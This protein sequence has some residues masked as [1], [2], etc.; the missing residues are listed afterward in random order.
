MTW[1]YV[2]ASL[3][4]SALTS[5]DYCFCL[6]VSYSQLHSISVGVQEVCEKPE[7]LADTF[8]SNPVR[9]EVLR[10]APV[11]GGQLLLQGVWLTGWDSQRVNQGLHVVG[12][13]IL[14]WMIWTKMMRTHTL[15]K[16]ISE[17]NQKGEEI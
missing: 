4:P 7:G 10:Q 3:W 6:S 16:F 14:C 17:R 11:E 12:T 8:A 2:R 15:N 5:L 13:Q 1:L 9:L